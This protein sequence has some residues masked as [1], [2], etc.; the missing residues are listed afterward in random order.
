MKKQTIL[1]TGITGF[2]GSNLA[3]KLVECGYNVIGIKRKT[4]QLTRIENILKLISLYNIEDVNF[5]NI[6]KDNPEISTVIHTATTYGRNNES[7]I[8]IFESNT[9]FPLMILDAASNAGVRKFINTDTILDKYLNLYSLSKNHL[10]EWGKF[11]SMNNK[12]AFVNMKLE[13]F[14]GPND[15]E[16][17]FTSNI[18]KNCILNTPEINLTPGLQLRDFI[19]IDDVVDAYLIVIEKLHDFQ[20]WFTEFEVGSGIPISIKYFVDT[21]H[22]YTNSKSKLKYGAIPYREGEV[23]YS[24]AN[25]TELCKLGW[26]VKFDL[27]SGL[28][29]TLKI[30]YK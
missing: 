6:F 12:I 3:F 28:K 27:E 21:V 14:Y 16:I 24:K 18:I 22:K 19:Y 7:P 26:N 8:E 13:H 10:F 30:N 23:M 5:T 4:S 29:K 9:S 15:E 20:Y 1:L 25:I 17:K 11:Y 2:L